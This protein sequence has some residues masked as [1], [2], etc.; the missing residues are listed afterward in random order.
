MSFIQKSLDTCKS[1]ANATLD[2]AKDPVKSTKHAFHTFKKMDGKEKAIW[3]LKVAAAALVA[4][5]IGSG[6]G[7]AFGFIAPVLTFVAIPSA[8]VGSIFGG[9]SMVAFLSRRKEDTLKI[10]IEVCMHNN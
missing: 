6:V 8:V 3:A 4:G 7:A 9:L 10:E 2:F 1:Y 5:L